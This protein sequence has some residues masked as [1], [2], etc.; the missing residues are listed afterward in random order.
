MRAFAR[1]TLIAAAAIALSALVSHVAV[2]VLKLKVTMLQHR[3][4]RA[5]EKPV[6]TTI[7]GSSTA[8][9]GVAWKTVA[10][11]L[12]DSLES[13]PVGGGSPL[14]WRA[15]QRRQPATGRVFVVVSPID[16]DDHFLCEF[17]ANLISIPEAVRDFPEG[18]GGWPF[19]GRLVDQYTLSFTRVLYPTAGRADG[20]MMGGRR[21]VARLAGRRDVGDSVTGRGLYQDEPS[22]ITERVSDWSAGR[23]EKELADMRSR[24]LGRHYFLGQKYRALVRLIHEVG[25]PGRVVLA[26]IPLS[27]AYWNQLLNPEDRREFQE[28]VG[29]VAKECPGILVLRN[30]QLPELLDDGMFRDLA[31]MNMFGQRA[32]TAAFLRGVTGAPPAP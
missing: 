31:H 17:R 3:V 15:I 23:L 26:V 16:M 1:L 29:R 24:S 25:E 32:S 12:G 6:G 11:S 4:F 5:G 21:L 22:D 14:E 13:W 7:F 2:R 8:F 30:D 20:V 27:Q 28:M 19:A 18:P 9:D 10:G